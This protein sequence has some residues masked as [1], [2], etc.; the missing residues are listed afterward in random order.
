MSKKSKFQ[1]RA[2]A[3]MLELATAAETCKESASHFQTMVNGAIGDAE[4]LDRQAH[5]L[6]TLI[7]AEDA[8]ES[9]PEE[10]P[11]V[12]RGEGPFDD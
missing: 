1:E 8:P 11:S 7:D 3:K 2:E 4:E 10:D 5:L 6:Q 12:A 9:V